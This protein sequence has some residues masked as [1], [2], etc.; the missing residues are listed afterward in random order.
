MNDLRASFAQYLDELALD[1]ARPR[2]TPSAMRRTRQPVSATWKIEQHEHYILRTRFGH[3]VGVMDFEV[4]RVDYHDQF[5]RPFCLRRGGD[6]NEWTHHLDEAQPL[7]RGGVRWDGSCDYRFE[8]P[9][10]PARAA[11]RQELVDLGALFA[12]VYDAALEYMPH[13]AEYLAP[14]APRDTDPAP[15]DPFDD[16]SYQEFIAEG[17]RL[18]RCCSDCA[19]VPCAGILAG[20]LCDGMCHC[21]DDRDYSMDYDD[22]FEQEEDSG[23]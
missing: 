9:S 12:R 7:M 10:E 8:H 18:C 23:S 19:Q 15:P 20:G 2:P 21:D 13:R 14:Q 17:I 4:F 11:K 1:D 16:P 6:G 22:D 5:L 3:R